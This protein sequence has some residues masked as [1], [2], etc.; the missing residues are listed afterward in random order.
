M[1]DRFY[2]VISFT[3]LYKMFKRQPDVSSNRVKL[4]PKEVLED[5]DPKGSL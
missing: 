1:R 4:A 5:L 3:G 2:V